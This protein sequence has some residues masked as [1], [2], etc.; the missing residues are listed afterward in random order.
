MSNLKYFIYIYFQKKNFPKY[1]R[2]PLD[3]SVQLVPKYFI[4]SYC[5]NWSQKLSKIQREL[6]VPK[7]L[8]ESETGNIW[9]SN[10]FYM[11]WFVP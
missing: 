5:I 7:Y 10:I 8:K 2:C 3:N 9:L 1:L 6:I 11:K 4:V